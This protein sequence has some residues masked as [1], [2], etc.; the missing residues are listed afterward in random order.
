MSSTYRLNYPKGYIQFSGVAC[1]AQMSDWIKGTQTQEQ[2]DNKKPF[3][4]TKARDGYEWDA[5][6]KPISLDVNVPG[7][8]MKSTSRQALNS[9]LRNLSVLPMF[10]GV[11]E[12]HSDNTWVDP[13]LFSFRINNVST[14]ANPVYFLLFNLARDFDENFVGRGN[15]VYTGID[16]NRNYINNGKAVLFYCLMVQRLIYNIG[17]HLKTVEYGIQGH[18]QAFCNNGYYLPLLKTACGM[19]PHEGKDNSCSY[20]IFLGGGTHGADAYWNQEGGVR[21]GA[22]VHEILKDATANNFKVKVAQLYTAITDGEL[23]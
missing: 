7:C 6:V 10:K 2:L 21:V 17:D 11:I 4:L 1:Y 8:M 14:V 9:I 23:G 13:E 15:W 18:S 3:Y 12:K 20:N 16:Y 22:K 19:E 5:K